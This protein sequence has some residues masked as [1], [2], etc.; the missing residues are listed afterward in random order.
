[1]I[2][3]EAGKRSQQTGNILVIDDEPNLRYTLV[4]ILRKSGWEVSAA[5]TGREALR[6]MVSTNYDLIFLDLRLP[7]MGGLDVLR[8]IRCINPRMPVILLTGH[9]TLQSAMDSIRLGA[10]DYILKPIDPVI[11]VERTRTILRQQTIE[12]RR[13]EILDQ[14]KALQEELNSL[15]IENKENAPPLDTPNQEAR[16]IRHGELL[17]DLQTRRASYK[18]NVL[19]IPP[20]TFEYL[21]VLV[22]HSPGVVTYQGLVTEAQGYSTNINEARELVKWHVHILRQ[23]IETDPKKPQHLLNVRGEGYRLIIN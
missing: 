11:L 1:M 5:S 17:L 20:A 23:S 3:F 18:E 21:I 10:T 4:R 12:R 16:F 14:I 22:R 7:D 6:L 9:G 13:Q 2:P 8:E 15:G 19:S